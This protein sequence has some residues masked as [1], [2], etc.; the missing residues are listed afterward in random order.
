M[1][2]LIVNYKNTDSYNTA[3]S[4]IINSLNLYQLHNLVFMQLMNILKLIKSL[5]SYPI[6]SISVNLSTD[7]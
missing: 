6:S 3:F 7:K 5:L 2:I 1:N 4:I